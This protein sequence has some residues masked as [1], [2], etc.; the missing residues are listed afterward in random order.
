MEYN[1][2]FFKSEDG[3]FRGSG[4]FYEYLER[5]ELLV[6][7]G[8]RVYNSGLSS[9]NELRLAL[10]FNGKLYDRYQ[11]EVCPEDVLDSLDGWGFD[12]SYFSCLPESERR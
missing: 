3:L 8:I 5:D 1:I 2:D 10:G 11:K 4:A 12:G 9:G 6:G 7:Q